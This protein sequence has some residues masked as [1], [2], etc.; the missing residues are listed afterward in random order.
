MGSGGIRIGETLTPLTD[1]L[2]PDIAT[3]LGASSEVEPYRVSGAFVYRL[4]LHLTGRPDVT[5]V[6][7]PSLG[8]ADV[9]T[10][11]CVVV[12]REI[13][14][15]LLFPGQEVVFQR[16]PRR[17]FLLVSHGGRVATAS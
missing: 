10:G 16:A 12:F 9:R 15:V 6:L 4:T 11:D 7:W 5:L 8:R 2:V 17:G 3:A 14:N 13:N 1:A